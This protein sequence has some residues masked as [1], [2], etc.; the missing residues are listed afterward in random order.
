MFQIANTEHELL[1]F[2]FEHSERSIDFL[3]I[4]LYK[5][6]RFTTS[7]ILDT[8][9]F[10]K[11]TETYQY[12][13]RTSTH[14]PSVFKG[15]IKGESLRH[16]RLNSNPTNLKIT[17]KHFEKKLIERGYSKA[18]IKIA[19][20]EALKTPRKKALTTSKNRSDSQGTPLTMVTL[21]HPSVGNLGSILRKHWSV[22]N[23]DPEA[24]QL[25]TRPPIV[26]FKRSRNISDLITS[27]LVRPDN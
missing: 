9:S 1:K 18:E 26:A 20:E 22:I 25:F 17:L 16:L 10:I 3:D 19:I 24:N 14:P 13:Q 27:S 11:K 6:E 15:L 4:T 7:G 12:L 23:N 8:K 5:G 21:Y 2:T